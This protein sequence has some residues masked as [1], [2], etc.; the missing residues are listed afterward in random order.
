[1]PAAI[2]LFQIRM[3]SKGNKCQIYVY[4]YVA[5]VL[6]SLGVLQMLDRYSATVMIIRF[7]QHINVTPTGESERHLLPEL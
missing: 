6:D 1:M 2:L 3:R 4:V 7:Q 5:A